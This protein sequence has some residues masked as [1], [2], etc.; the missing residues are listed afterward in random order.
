MKWLCVY[1]FVIISFE[2][3]IASSINDGST[4][5]D[6]LRAELIELEEQSWKTIDDDRL[7]QNRKLDQIVARHESFASINLGV[8]YQE[9]DFMVLNHMFDWKDIEN[10]LVTITK[11]FAEYRRFLK[12]QVREGHDERTNLDFAETTLDDTSW[13][14]KEIFERI[15]KVMV[16][17]GLYYKAQLVSFTHHTISIIT[18]QTLLCYSSCM[19]KNKKIVFDSTQ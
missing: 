10:D 16:D 6:E 18:E 8:D 7:P 1:F 15:F 13:N 11:L 17:H 9:N 19:N 4:V 14:I 12:L 2:N 3:S 5:I